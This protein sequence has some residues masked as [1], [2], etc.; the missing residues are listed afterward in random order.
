MGC[1]IH[2]LSLRGIALSAPRSI[3]PVG[4]EPNVTLIVD[5]QGSGRVA[6]RTCWGPHGKLQ[7][8]CYYSE[9]RPRRSTLGAMAIALGRA[10]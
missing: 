7:E 10:S 8:I 9:S 6:A 5:V 1:R 2:T 3:V 4:R